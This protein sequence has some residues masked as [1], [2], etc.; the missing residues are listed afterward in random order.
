[1]CKSNIFQNS[2]M[3]ESSILVLVRKN[4]SESLTFKE[5]KTPNIL[6]SLSLSPISLT[7]VL[8]IIY[9]IKY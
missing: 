7:L 2:T 4:I 8:S 3:K 1:M 6:L 5:G 9:L